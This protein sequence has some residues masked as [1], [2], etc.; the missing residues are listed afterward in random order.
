LA[1]KTAFQSAMASAKATRDASL[2]ALGSKPV[3]PA[4]PS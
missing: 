3:K 4:R 2:A 1:A